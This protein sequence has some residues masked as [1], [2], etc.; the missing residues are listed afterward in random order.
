[1]DK[2]L[3]ELVREYDLIIVAIGDEWNWIRKGLNEDPRYS[4]LLHYAEGENNKWLLPIIEYEY[5]MR[6]SDD[7]TESAYKALREL[8]GEKSYFL[9]SDIFIHDAPKYGFDPDHCVFP[10]G[11]YEYLQT[12]DLNDDL[13]KASECEDF[14]R[15][16]DYIRNIV[17]EK[18]GALQEGESFYK[19]F[20]DGKLLYL[21][22]KRSEY[23]N[24]NYNEKAYLNNW[25]RYM[26]YLTATL[27]K[28][29]LLLELGV[30][31]DYPTVIRW[32]FEKVAFLNK[33]ARL[34]RVHERLYHHTPEIEDK[35]DSVQMNS[36]DYILQESTRQ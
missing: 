10:C 31:L 28:S 17:A 18:G 11:N 35:T 8:I 3:K 25:E 24:I 6:N 27:N 22:Q 5:A 14:H 2:T 19:P 15:I 23:S 32:P 33:K 13:I 7:R 9:V 4:E 36:V 21:N 20:F 26:K 12:N 34:V 16:I 1:M 29:L 30:G